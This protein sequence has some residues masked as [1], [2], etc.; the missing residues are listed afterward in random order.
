MDIAT[1]TTPLPTPSP[2]GRGE[3]NAREM[4][5]PT[6]AAMPEVVRVVNGVTH[7][8]LTPETQACISAMEQDAMARLKQVQQDMQ[9]DLDQAISRMMVGVLTQA[10]YPPQPYQVSEDRQTLILTAP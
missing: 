8:V 7:L 5:L 6:L 4:A 2:E 10:G 9:Q 3:A 1:K